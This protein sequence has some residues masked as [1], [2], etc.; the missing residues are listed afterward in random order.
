[1]ILLVLACTAA[2]TTDKPQRDSGDTAP[3][4]SADTGEGDTDTDTDS[5]TDTAASI[6]EGDDHGSITGSVSSANYTSTLTF[7][8]TRM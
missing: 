3:V 4:D 1:M 2:V 5:D 7:V 8:G 6:A